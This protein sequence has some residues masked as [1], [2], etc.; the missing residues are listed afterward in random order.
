MLLYKFKEHVLKI[1]RCWD[2]YEQ[3]YS[4]FKI[5]Y[6]DGIC[7]STHFF[8]HYRQAKSFFRDMIELI[9]DVEANMP[10]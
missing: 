3:E 9:R 8:P 5:V 7:K 1:E 6:D 2:E 4:G 10:F